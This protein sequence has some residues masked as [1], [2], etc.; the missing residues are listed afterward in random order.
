LSADDD[1]LEGLMDN[2]EPVALGL[3]R[4]MSLRKHMSAKEE[5]S[6]E[7]RHDAFFVCSICSK[8]LNDPMECNK[9]DTPFCGDCIETWKQSNDR[10][11]GKDSCVSPEYIP[12]HRFVKNLLGEHRFFC[13]MESC[14]FN[15]KVQLDQLKMGVGN[16]DFSNLGMSYSEASK[17]QL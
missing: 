8:V 7:K 16:I 15:K 3:S 11:P 14:Q 10:C 9:C 6:P 5:G 12:M 13:P 2:V 17:H 4:S 1:D